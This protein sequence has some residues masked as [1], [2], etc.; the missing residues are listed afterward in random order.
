MDFALKLA[1]G[2][3]IE[4]YDIELGIWD[5]TFGNDFLVKRVMIDR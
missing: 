4:V 1:L 5:I 2:V 3:S